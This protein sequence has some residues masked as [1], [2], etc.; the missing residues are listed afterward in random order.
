M[1]EIKHNFEEMRTIPQMYPKCKYKGSFNLH[2][3]PSYGLESRV[4]QDKT[5]EDALGKEWRDTPEVQP[6]PHEAAAHETGPLP[7]TAH[8]ED[9]PSGK[10]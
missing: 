2:N 10:K 9:K 3:P 5:E 6:E 4:V 8:K 1:A 7:F